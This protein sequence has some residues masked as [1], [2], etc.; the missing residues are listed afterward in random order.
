MLGT[1][2]NVAA[3]LV[4]GLLGI[5]FRKFIKKELLEAVLKVVGMVVLLF[6][7]IG[8][9]QSMVHIESGILKTEG[10]L[11]LLVCLAVG[12]LLGELLKI[13]EHLIHFGEKLENKLNK[14]A[15]S[16]GFITASLI[17]C[18]GAMAIIGSISAAAGN[19][20]VLYLKAAIDGITAMILASTLGIGVLFSGITVFI[21]QGSITLLSSALDSFMSD[22]FINSFNAVGYVIVGCIGLNFLR[23]HKLK[24][25][26]MI[27]SLFLVIVYY[28]IRLIG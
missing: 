20:Q 19:Y 11:L 22:A 16:E 24:I 4:G 9:L 15:F 7:L 8:V 25:A 28:L 5:L 2:V 26:N 13:D 23:E 27:P 14:G 3:I 10:E 18:V 12:T 6:G 17:F 21:Y 1:I